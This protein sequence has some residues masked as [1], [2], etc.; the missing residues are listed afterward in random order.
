LTYICFGKDAQVLE[1]GHLLDNLFVLR[2]ADFELQL[3]ICVDCFTKEEFFY[4]CDA[5]FRS[6]F[7]LMEGFILVFESDEA[8]LGQRIGVRTKTTGTHIK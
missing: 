6:D 5:D 4:V 8:L 7:R 2:I 1:N 3:E